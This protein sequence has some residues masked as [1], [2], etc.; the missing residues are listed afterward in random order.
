MIQMPFEDRI[1]A[2]R[3]LAHELERR[4]IPAETIVVGIAR[5]GVPVAYEVADRLHFVLDVIAA[6][7]IAAPW[8]PEITLGA[9]VGAE[10]VLDDPLIDAMGISSCDLNEIVS[11]EQ[12]VAA[13]ENV[14]YH[15]DSPILNVCGRPVVVID[16]GLDTGDTMLAAV[17]EIRRRQPSLIVA[18]APVGPARAFDRLRK[19]ADQIVCV[20]IPAHFI[21][22]G[23]YFR[24]FDD[25]DDEAIQ[26]LLLANRCQQARFQAI[27]DRCAVS[28]EPESSRAGLR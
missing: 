20:E 18:A 11:R 26:N 23:E 7:R 19:Q 10:S 6:R 9:I 28:P 15:R 2:G 27:K 17:R 25:V 8:Q 1:W 4:G 12:D 16:D 14:V 5:G 24:H 22:K 13:Q 21:A 3:C